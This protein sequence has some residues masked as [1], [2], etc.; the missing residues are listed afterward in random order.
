MPVLFL[1]M[2]LVT[3]ISL[4]LD[5]L[6]GF[7]DF[8]HFYRLSELGWPYLDYWVEFPPLFPLISKL[9]SQLAG[10]QEHIYDYVL[11]V[12]LSLAQMGSLIVFLKL[13]YRHFTETSARW[14]SWVYMVVLLSLSYGWWYFDPLVEV[15]SLVSIYLLIRMKEVPTGITLAV[16]TSLKFFPSLILPAVWKWLPRRKAIVTTIITLG[17]TSAI[18]LVLYLLSPDYTSASIRSQVSKGSWE[19]IWALLDRN[20]NTGN[21]GTLLERYDPGTALQPRGNPAIIPPFITLI[22][23]L[24]LGLW[25]FWRVKLSSGIMVIAFTGITWSLFF[26]WSPGWSPQWVIY[27]LPLILLTLAE[28]EALLFSVVLVLLNIMEWPLLLSRGYQWGLWITIPAR[29]IIMIL[30]SWVWYKILFKSYTSTDE[31]IT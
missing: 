26:L 14:R 8:S 21:F 9:L 7:G 10:E 5:G 15:F 18:F 22:P 19:T 16:G 24:L 12:F 2:R 13:A 28:R 1:L 27:L 6:R 17:M 11:V 31:H 4:P 20:F 30:L 25:I 23:F 29:T 3:I